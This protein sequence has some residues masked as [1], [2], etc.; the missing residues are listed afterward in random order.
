MRAARAAELAL[1]PSGSEDPDPHEQKRIL[2]GEEVVEGFYGGEFVVFDVENGIELGDVQ[3]VANFLGEVKEFEFATSVARG[4]EGAD[5]FSHAR[6]V[7][8]V[9][10]GEVEDDFLF[11]IGEQVADGSAEIADF[12]A[13]DET[14]VDVEDGDVGNFAGVNLQ[15]HDPHRGLRRMVVCGREQVNGGE[16]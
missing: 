13:E 14:A 9:D 6:A 8:I 10:A 5:Q 11:A 4:G 15:R 12:G 1:G 16:R 7:E 2:F 3:D